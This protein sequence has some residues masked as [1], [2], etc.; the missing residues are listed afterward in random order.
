M[1][2]SGEADENDM[3][4]LDRLYDSAVT[5]LKKLDEVIYKDMGL[6]QIVTTNEPSRGSFMQQDFIEVYVK[7]EPDKSTVI[8]LDQ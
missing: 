2:Q 6:L 5:Q 4:I 7:K 8:S 3:N 1:R